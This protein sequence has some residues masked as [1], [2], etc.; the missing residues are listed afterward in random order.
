MNLTLLG[1]GQLDIQLR[2]T[3]RQISD[4]SIRSTRPVLAGRGSSGRTCAEVV[5]AL[6][7]VYS[8][9]GV[10]QTV[11]AAGACESALGCSIGDRQRRARYLLVAA[12]TAREHLSRMFLEW[13]K[14][15]GR[16]LEVSAART[17]IDLVPTLRRALSRHNDPLA[18]GHQTLAIDSAQ[19]AQACAGLTNLL[20]AQ[21]FGTSLAE[22]Q[23]IADEADLRAWAAATPTTPAR[24]IQQVFQQ[25]WSAFGRST[26]AA[27]PALPQSALIE[28]LLGENSETT[29]VLGSTKAR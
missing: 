11:A 12:E 1:E 25:G 27:L 18:F 10:A 9:C 8:V 16:P 19:C 2:L 5:S 17:A 23:H 6:P 4:V 7:L 20:A 22:W 15:L 3:D 14:W 13:P 28:R 26:V 24:I 21:V 29:L